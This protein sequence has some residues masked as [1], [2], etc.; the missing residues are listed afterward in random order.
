MATGGT[1]VLSVPTSD[2]RELVL[3]IGGSSGRDTDKFEE[4]QLAV[5]EPGVFSGVEASQQTRV[6]SKQRRAW[7]EGS[8]R[9][10]FTDA[11]AHLVCRVDAELDAVPNEAN[12][13][14]AVQGACRSLFLLLLVILRSKYN[15]SD[16]AKTSIIALHR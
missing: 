11:A 4:F 6:T 7:P 5:D 3:R 12:E 2:M 15:F 14:S 9:I 16:V 8:F 13:D 1:F 10:A